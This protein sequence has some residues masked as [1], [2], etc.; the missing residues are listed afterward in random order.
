MLGYH[1]NSTYV[2][3][4]FPDTYQ[5]VRYLW[6]LTKVLGDISAPEKVKSKRWWGVRVQINNFSPHKRCLLHEQMLR[7]M[8]VSSIGKL[9]PSLDFHL[10]YANI[11]EHI[12]ALVPFLT[13][14]LRLL[15]D[16]YSMS[17][18]PGDAGM[19]G[20]LCFNWMLTCKYSKG[21]GWQQSE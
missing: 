13:L 17:S 6:G 10:F 15:S 9:S 2:L 16:Y 7:S 5:K 14:C 12:D 4:D 3:N 11:F 1:K 18:G 19:Q 20:I 21:V 8:T